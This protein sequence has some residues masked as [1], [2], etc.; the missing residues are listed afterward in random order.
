[1][2]MCVVRPENASLQPPTSVLP[3]PCASGRSVQQ[4]NAVR[5]TLSWPHAARAAHAARIA[6]PRQVWMRLR[7]PKF[8]REI[9]DF[10]GHWKVSSPAARRCVTPC[11][12]GVLLPGEAREKKRHF[13]WKVCQMHAWLR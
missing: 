9:S 7:R 6:L 11:G 1:M 5:V 8:R 3:T 13:R 2:S 12:E 10:D 4:G